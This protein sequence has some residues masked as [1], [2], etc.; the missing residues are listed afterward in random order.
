MP[1][2]FLTSEALES[3]FSVS[4]RYA[5]SLGVMS[6][7][8]TIKRRIPENV[9][10][11]GHSDVSTILVSGGERGGGGETPLARLYY[12]R[13]AL[14]YISRDALPARFLSVF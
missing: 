4:Y 7:K 8:K 13:C 14:W 3:K 1:S 9:S 12:M 11:S 6:E 10:P 2:R 5:S